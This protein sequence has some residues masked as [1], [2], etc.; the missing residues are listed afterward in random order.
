MK[1][2]LAWMIAA[3]FAAV[4]G[5][6]LLRLPPP[7]ASVPTLKGTVRRLRRTVSDDWDDLFI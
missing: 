1:A 5:G 2:R 7:A 4:A 6:V 3:A